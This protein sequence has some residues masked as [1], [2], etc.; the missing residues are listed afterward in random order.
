MRARGA[1][2]APRRTTNQP[3]GPDTRTEPWGGLPGACGSTCRRCVDEQHQER[4]RPL[5]AWV[6]SKCSAPVDAAQVCV[7]LGERE[8]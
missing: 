5:A 3:T 1:K 6:C 8:G 4:D 2:R 7:A